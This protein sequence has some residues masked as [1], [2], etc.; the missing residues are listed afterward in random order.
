MRIQ[1]TL[2]RVLELSRAHE[3]IA[4]GKTTSATNVRWALNTATT[5]GCSEST[6][7]FIVSIIDGRVGTIGR[8]HFPGD[9]LQALVRESEEACAGKPPAGD[10]LPL[11]EGNGPGP[12]W[13]DPGEPAGMS[14]FSRLGPDLA[15]A[16][17]RARDHGILLFG[18]AEH[19]HSTLYLATSS[20]LRR[21]F[22]GSEGKFQINAKT[23]DFRLSTWTGQA[24]TTFRDVDISGCE[25][26]L[27]QRLEWSKKQLS[28]PPGD[29][30]VILEPCAV[31]DMLVEAYWNGSARDAEEGRSA[32]SR[33]GGGTRIG[34]TI[35]AEALSMYSDPWEPGLEVTPFV[36]A[37]ES[38]GVSSV[39]DN[40]LETGRIDWVTGGK[41]TGL[42]TTRYQAHRTGTAPKPFVENLIVPGTGS[43]LDQM[44]ASTG[45]ALLVTC[46]WYIRM[47]DPQTML[48]TGLTRDGIFLIEDGQVK[49]AVNNFRFNM[50][51]LDLMKKTVEIGRSQPTLA[52]EFG[53][54]FTFVKVPPLRVAGFHMSSVS[55][56][57]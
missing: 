51:P 21:R 43:E 54:Y 34:E 18:F 53:D 14:V 9:D 29:Y 22:C 57:V 48:L 56:S 31:A 47:V 3:C 23:P 27:M 8:N 39:F 1:D 26:R 10:A 30:E 40:G 46:L 45:R 28:L 32:Y 35:A 42:I 38:S 15:G 6:Q 4:L 13:P 16:F 24:T 37:V 20:G 17:R 19:T 12:G 55:P 33:P 11:L 41:L 2:E 5:S 49:G 7:L 25:K 52:R 44:I 50:S 36:V